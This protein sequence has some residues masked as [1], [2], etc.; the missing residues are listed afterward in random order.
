MSQGFWMVFVATLGWLENRNIFPDIDSRH[1]CLRRIAEG[2]SPDFRSKSQFI[3][4][5]TR[6]C[7]NSAITGVNLVEAAKHDPDTGGSLSEQTPVI[8][9]FSAIFSMV[10]RG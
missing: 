5:A 8:F 3:T 2:S 10:L 9:H 7:N 4:R 1:H 6:I